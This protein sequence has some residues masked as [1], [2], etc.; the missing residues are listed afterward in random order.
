VS[1]KQP[2]KKSDTLVPVEIIQSKIYLIRGRK[3]MLDRDLAELYG[4]DTSQLTR[5]VRRN[6]ER[7]PSDFLIHLGREE[8]NSLICQFGTSKRGGTRKLPLAFT[9]NYGDTQ[10]NNREQRPIKNSLTL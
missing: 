7:F 5:Q 1:T 2:I 8:F 4:V 3:V 6:L 9:E 10:L